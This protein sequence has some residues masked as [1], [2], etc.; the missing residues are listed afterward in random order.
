MSTFI[1][2]K[3]RISNL[4]GASRLSIGLQLGANGINGTGKKATT[5]PLDSEHVFMQE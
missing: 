4:S 3:L 2:R 5:G 1:V